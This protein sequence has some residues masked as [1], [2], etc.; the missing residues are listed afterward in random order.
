MAAAGTG[1]ADEVENCGLV[2][3]PGDATALA[4]GIV[5]LLDAPA[6][7]REYGENG[8]RRALERWDRGSVIASLIGDLNEL[9][10]ADGAR[11]N[12]AVAAGAIEVP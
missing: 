12:A 3:T 7:C 4:G 8:R 1:L 6:R 11:V 5:D 2:V 10:A 9:K